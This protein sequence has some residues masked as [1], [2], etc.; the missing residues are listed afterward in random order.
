M[1]FIC[2]YLVHFW[3]WSPL[4]DLRGLLV[5]FW[6][7]FWGTRL[8]L[9][10]P[11]FCDSVRPILVPFSIP[12]YR[13]YCS[14]SVYWSIYCPSF[15]L[16]INSRLETQASQFLSYMPSI[17][18]SDHLPTFPSPRATPSNW[19]FKQLDGLSRP[20]T[21]L[22]LCFRS[23]ALLPFLI[24]DVNDR[25]LIQALQLFSYAALSLLSPPSLSGTFS[26]SCKS[27]LK[28]ML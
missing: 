21:I 14:L 17:L 15:A 1:H 7:W 22:S 25:F 28:I 11:F 24:E 12:L 20:Y 13:Y 18:Q 6:L 23:V 9:A 16:S 8:I 5:H 27:V 10:L 4:I 19:I 3:L 26:A 2:H